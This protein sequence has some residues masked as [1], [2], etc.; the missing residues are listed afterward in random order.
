M[1]F[2]VTQRGGPEWLFRPFLTLGA[3]GSRRLL[4]K[5][6]KIDDGRFPGA[7]QYFEA[8]KERVALRKQRREAKAKDESI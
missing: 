6:G 3:M 2:P 1:L 4:E 5:Q 8:E 7:K